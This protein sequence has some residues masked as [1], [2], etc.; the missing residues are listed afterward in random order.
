MILINGGEKPNVKVKVLE[1]LPDGKLGLGLD[2]ADEDHR[3]VVIVEV[4]A[5]SKRFGW[6]VSDRII[7]VNGK[8]IDDWDDFSAAWD[9]AKSLGKAVF[10]I[11]RIGSEEIEE[12]DE[13]P[14]EPQCLH[15]GSKGKHLQKC[16]TWKNLPEGVD[17][18]YFCT[19]DC[20]REAWKAAKKAASA[21]T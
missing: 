15:C 7:E 5:K 13:G 6:E 9:L 4:S 19:R 20:Q 11:V 12:E 8:D 21:A 18:V 16:T 3:G 2:D 1:T 10:G 14:K 17:C